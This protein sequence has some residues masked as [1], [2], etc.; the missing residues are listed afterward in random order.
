MSTTKDLS[1]VLCPHC[2]VATPL[3][4]F[5]EEA[6]CSECDTLI[7]PA[8]IGVQCLGPA[9]VHEDSDDEE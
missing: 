8:C 4:H 9:F 7:E 1:H 3:V 5:H 2:G 6:R